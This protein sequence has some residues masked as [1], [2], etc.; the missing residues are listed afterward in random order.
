MSSTLTEQRPRGGGWHRLPGVVT[1]SVAESW[2]TDGSIVVGSSLV[3]AEL[4]DGS[5]RTGLQ[6]LVS[7]S[8]AGGKRPT[9]AEVRRALTAFDF[10]RTEEDNHHPGIARHFWRPVDPAARVACQC[11]D[12]EIT[13]REPDGYRWTTPRDGACRGCEMQALLGHPCPLHPLP[14]AVP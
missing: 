13:V 6:H 5:K 8:G 4:P 3:N 7:V 11:K 10:L 14:R 2:W 12:D 9:R 1:N